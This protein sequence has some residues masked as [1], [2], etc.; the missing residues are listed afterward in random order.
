MLLGT[1]TMM[2]AG[3]GFWLAWKLLHARQQNVLLHKEI[4][5]LRGRLR[6][7]RR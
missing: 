2:L 7:S 3:A 6:A 4:S 5:L 1:L